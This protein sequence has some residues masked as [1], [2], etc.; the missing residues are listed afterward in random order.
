METVYELW[1]NP[2]LMQKWF[3]SKNGKRGT[4]YTSKEVNSWYAMD[5]HDVDGS[6]SGIPDT[7]Y[8]CIGKIKE[9]IPNKKLVFTWLDDGLSH[10]TL[11]T[12][13]FEAVGGKTK[14][15]LIHSNIVEQNW[16]NDFSKGWDYCLEGQSKL[17]L[18]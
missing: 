11:V 14:L 18:N 9:I 15:T 6:E 3:N 8:R 17:L 2:E 10:E 5:Y 13:N 16:A 4:A 7:I 1:T 12:V